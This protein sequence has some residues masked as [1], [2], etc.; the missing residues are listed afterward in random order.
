MKI[1]STFL[2]ILIT[3][4]FLN[5]GCSVLENKDSTSSPVDSSEVKTEPTSQSISSPGVTLENFRKLKLGMN[6]DEV[7]EIL[8]KE[9]KVISEIEVSDLKTTQCEWKSNKDNLNAKISLTFINDKL[10]VKMQTGLE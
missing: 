10:K 7:V 4:L 6:Y 5:L 8:G 2:I 9:G 1:A 3:V